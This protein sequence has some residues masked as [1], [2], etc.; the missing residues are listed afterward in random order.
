[1][2]KSRC[3]LITTENE[4]LGLQIE[5]L[6]IRVGKDRK[7]ISKNLPKPAIISE[8]GAFIELLQIFRRIVYKFSDIAAPFQ[9]QPGNEEV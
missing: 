3:E 6:E 2:E 9:D 4:F 7:Q 5:S 1:M 8:L